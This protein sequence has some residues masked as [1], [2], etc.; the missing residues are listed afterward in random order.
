MAQRGIAVKWR[1]EVD[2]LNGA[3]GCRS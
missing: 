2:W 1:K 3:M